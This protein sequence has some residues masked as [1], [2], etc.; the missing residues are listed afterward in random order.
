M[1]SKEDKTWLLSSRYSCLWKRQIYNRTLSLIVGVARQLLKGG[2]AGGEGEY[3]SVGLCAE[4]K[5]RLLVENV[6]KFQDNSTDFKPI[7]GLL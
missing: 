1:D 4:I 3:I 5:N 7:I 6:L 2:D